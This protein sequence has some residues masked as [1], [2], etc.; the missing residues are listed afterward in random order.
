MGK[1][2]SFSKPSAGITAYLL[3]KKILCHYITPYTKN[4]S[5]GIADLDLRAKTIKT[6]DE[7]IGLNL[8]ERELD[9]IS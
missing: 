9:Q 1:K 5:K 4:I 8:C 3:T 2:I 6:L 7:Y